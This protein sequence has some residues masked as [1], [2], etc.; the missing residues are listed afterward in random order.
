M[1]VSGNIKQINITDNSKLGENQGRKAT[2][3]KHVYDRRAAEENTENELY[4]SAY[5][6]IFGEN[7]KEVGE[8]QKEI[9]IHL[10]TSTY[11]TL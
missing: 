9:P 2:G 5:S 7:E 3:L 11:R 6:F 4:V 8:E 1:D 10:R